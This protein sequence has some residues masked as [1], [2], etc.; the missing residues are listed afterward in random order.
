MPESCVLDTGHRK[1]HAEQPAGHTEHT[2][3]NAQE[4]ALLARY[5]S[6]MVYETWHDGQKG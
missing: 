3:P 6:E 4:E 5:I 2:G 1:R